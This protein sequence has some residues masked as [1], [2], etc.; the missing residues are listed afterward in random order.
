MT[1]K[2]PLLFATCLMGISGIS[3]AADSPSPNA[4]LE[5]VRIDPAALKTATKED[6]KSTETFK[7]LTGKPKISDARFYK[8]AD[9]HFSV[10]VSSLGITTLALKDWE[11]DQFVHFFSGNV[12]VT[13]KSGK[14]QRFGP[15]DSLIIPKGYSGSW[16]NLSPIRIITIY[17]T[18][19]TP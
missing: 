5:I 7:I 4:N 18:P 16:K 11:S 1:V 3:Y 17:Y 10:G 15:G 8:S 13:E 19:T 2:K 14:I 12:V 6:A 9:N